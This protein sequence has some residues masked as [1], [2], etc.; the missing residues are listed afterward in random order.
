MY[1]FFII[2]AGGA[3]G[4]MARHG[5]NLAAMRLF[6]M[7]FPWGTLAVNV[8]GSFLMGVLAGLF[9]VVWNAPQDV[10]LFLTTGLL[11]GFTTFSAFSLDVALLWERGQAP[12]ALAYA[13]GSVMI[14]VLALFSG[15]AL[16]RSFAG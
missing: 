3:A 16:G 7:D 5:V 13:A 1:A 11:G 9:A 14:S 6:G 12:H 8:S 15:L 2:G 10:R 4:A